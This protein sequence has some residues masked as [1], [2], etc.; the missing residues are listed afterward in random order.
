MILGS[1]SRS[2]HALPEHKKSG[3]RSIVI[4]QAALPQHND[5]GE[6]QIVPPKRRDRIHLDIARV[7]GGEVGDNSLPN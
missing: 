5:V 1:L 3:T 2:Q 4:K 6:P 7:I